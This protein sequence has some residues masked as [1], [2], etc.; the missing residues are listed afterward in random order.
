MKKKAKGQCGNGSNKKNKI[1][2]RLR[3]RTLIIAGTF[4]LGLGF[5]GVFLPLLPT[6]PFLLLAAACYARSSKRAY[7]WLL[8]NKLFGS[9]IKNY[10]EGKGVPLKVKVLSISLLWLTIIFSAMFLVHIIFVR[11]I[12]IFIAIAITIHILKIRTLKQSKSMVV[13]A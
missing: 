3:R 6:T 7:N 10:R 9:Y 13:D 2:D 8:N 11:I 4:F 1:S 12:L 5:L